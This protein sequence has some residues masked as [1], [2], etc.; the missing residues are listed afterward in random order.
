VDDDYFSAIKLTAHVG[1]KDVVDSVPCGAIINRF[2]HCNHKNM[3]P[4]STLTGP[5][6]LCLFCSMQYF[7]AIRSVALINGLHMQRM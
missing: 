6:L 7:D 3:Y 2:V 1:L 5:T 4:K